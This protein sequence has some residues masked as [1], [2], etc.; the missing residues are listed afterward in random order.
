[1]RV[2]C[3]PHRKPPGHYDTLF[4]DRIQADLESRVSMSEAKQL[5]SVR[6]ARRRIGPWGTAARIGLGTLLLT[7]AIGRGIGL[8]DLFIA[9]IVLPLAV[10]VVLT[11]RGRNAPGLRLFGT[12]GYV[13]NYGIGAVLLLAVTTPALIFYGVSML[14]AAARDYPG[15]EIL[16]ISNWVTRRDD[17]MACPVFSPID[18]VEAR[19]RRAS[20]LP[21]I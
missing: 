10:I 1:M 7:V 3:E 2:Q 13:T 16:A 20:G 19:Q 21:R 17:R 5:G 15:C 11:F 18:G 6:S 12:M 4:G 14:I 9:V 8:A